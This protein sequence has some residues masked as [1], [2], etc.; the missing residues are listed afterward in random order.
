M[1]LILHIS[2]GGTKT[3][4]S[5]ALAVVFAGPGLAAEHQVARPFDMQMIS[6]EIGNAA[7]G[8]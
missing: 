8:I 1:F 3:V 6:I 2:S 4:N 5:P 7:T